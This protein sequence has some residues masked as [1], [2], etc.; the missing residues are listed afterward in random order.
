VAL[1]E[2]TR[3]SHQSLVDGVQI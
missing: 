1:Q 2:E 3:V